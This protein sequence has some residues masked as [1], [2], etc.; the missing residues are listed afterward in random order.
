[1][2]TRQTS[3]SEKE[4]QMR[5]ARAEQVM[6]HPLTIQFLQDN[7]DAERAVRKNARNAG[8]WIIATCGRIR[9]A[10]AGMPTKTK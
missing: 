8:D 9:P 6:Q 2:M 10:A 3:V 4:R 1:M 5:T 7:P